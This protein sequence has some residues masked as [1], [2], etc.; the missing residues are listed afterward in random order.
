MY[1]F[2]VSVLDISELQQQQQQKVQRKTPKTS[3]AEHDPNYT[4][5]L[6]EKT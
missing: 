6:V 3:F 4:K 1:S 5:L 2:L